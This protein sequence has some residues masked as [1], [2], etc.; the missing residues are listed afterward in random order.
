VKRVAL[1]LVAALA[2]CSEERQPPPPLG[3]DSS[4][5]VT[6]CVSGPNSDAT[7]FIVRRDGQLLQWFR[8][9]PQ[10][11]AIEQTQALRVLDAEETA[12]LF[13][14][15]GEMNFAGIEHHKMGPDL[16]CYLALRSEAQGVIHEVS[17]SMQKG[18]PLPVAQL[19]Q[20][21][22]ALTRPET[23]GGGSS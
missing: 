20:R 4:E 11:I 18:A 6:G 23:G 22:D 17:W 3:P 21:I 16:T 5:I 14:A 15:L 13:A 9:G 8:Q 10:P 1:V 12:S 2:A 7:G 19:F